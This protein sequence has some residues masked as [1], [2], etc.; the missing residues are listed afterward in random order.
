MESHGDTDVEL[1]FHLVDQHCPPTLSISEDLDN[2]AI[3]ESDNPNK[4][5]HSFLALNVR[6]L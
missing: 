2:M 1:S 4:H 5:P 6:Y 3:I